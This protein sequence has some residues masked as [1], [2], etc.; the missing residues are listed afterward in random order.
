MD[1]SKKLLEWMD[2]AAERGNY[3]LRKTLC[4]ARDII[5]GL[6]NDSDLHYYVSKHLEPIRSAFASMNQENEEL[7]EIVGLFEDKIKEMGI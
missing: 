6:F 7:I 2:V 3:E 4:I 1:A 5:D